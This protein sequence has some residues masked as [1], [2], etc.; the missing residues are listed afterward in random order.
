M[1]YTILVGGEAGQ[2]LA[3]TGGALAEVFSKIGFNVITH[4]DYMDRIRGGHNFNQIRFSDH[5]I[6]ASRKMIDILLALDLN[7]IEIHKNSVKDEGFIL[8]DSEAIK[9][10]FEGSQFV[11]VPFR[12]IALDVGKKSVMANTV[13]TGAALGIFN[14]GL[15]AFKDILKKAFKDKGE[16]VVKGNIACAEAGYNYVRKN[17]P[18]CD[19]SGIHEPEYRKLM[20]IDGVSA[21]GM[22]ALMSGCKFYAGYPMTPATGILDYIASRAEEYNM[23]AVQSED[24][25]AAINMAIG[26]SFAGLRAMTGTSGGGF[27][28]MVEGLS[29]AGM[30]ETPIV[31]AEMQRPGPATGMPTRTEQADLLYVLHAGHGEFPRVIFE[32]GTP[33]QAF[34]LTNKA[35]DLAEKYQIPTFILS[36]QYLANSKWT[37]ENFDLEHLIY[38]EYRLRQKD[39]EGV[40]DYKRFKYTDTGVSPF[41]VPGEAGKNLVVADSDEHDEEGHM[42]EDGETRNKMVQKRVLK[43]MPL[44]KK[45]IEP[46]LLYGDSSPKIVLVVHGST[47]GVIKEIVDTSPKEKKVAMLHFSQ[48][49]PFPERDNF[50]YIELLKNA[51]LSIC[52]ENN[53]TGQFARLIRAETGFEFSHQISKYDGRPY[54]FENLKEDLHAYI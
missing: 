42:I 50:D 52:I 20:L 39:L 13:A 27:A 21:I 54:L 7:T 8:Y 14:I 19:A 31:I 49:Y 40:E 44:I 9:K 45:E 6:S 24:E 1:D 15:E 33:E 23:V 16:E 32:P 18:P 12:K 41:A 26:A 4:E 25:I 3:T 48:I 46:P 47:Y 28:L 35:F 17:C 29:L 11:D 5:E 30:T 51:D 22:G 38:N 37:F 34:Y 43:K 2:G 53:A 36:D 10:K